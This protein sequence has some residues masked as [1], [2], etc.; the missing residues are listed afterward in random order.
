MSSTEG[1]GG[2]EPLRLSK[3]PVEKPAIPRGGLMFTTAEVL[4][5]TGS[6]LT[7]V[8]EEDGFAL[9]YHDVEIVC[10]PEEGF[11]TCRADA[12]TVVTWEKLSAQ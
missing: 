8:F 2:G 9:T 7:A 3:E 6:K 12:N 11:V 10:V 5:A 4:S 1:S